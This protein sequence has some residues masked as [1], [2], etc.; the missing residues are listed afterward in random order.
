[1]QNSERFHKE[2][3]IILT[4][5]VCGVR[6]HSEMLRVLSIVRNKLSE[7]GKVLHDNISA[8]YIAKHYID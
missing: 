4:G 6:K 1:M 2:Q 8:K 5:R 3:Y 7:N